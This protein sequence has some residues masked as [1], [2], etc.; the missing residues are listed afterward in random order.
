MKDISAPSQRSLM[1]QLQNI[2]RPISQKRN[3]CHLTYYLG[4]LCLYACICM[5]VCAREKRGGVFLVWETVGAPLMICDVK[6]E[7]GR[8]ECLQVR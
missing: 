8:R 7:M 5:C 1:L 3:R 2:F 6:I 4:I